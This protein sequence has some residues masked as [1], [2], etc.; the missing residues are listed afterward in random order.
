MKISDGDH[1]INAVVVD[2]RK[3][4]VDKSGLKQ[5]RQYDII[6]LS[7]FK[8]KQLQS[9]IS[10]KIHNF[11]SLREWPRC[12]SEQ[13]EIIGEPKEFTEFRDEKNF[14]DPQKP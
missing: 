2:P 5:I 1:F 6:E 8:L 3:G 4:N 14:T 12:L 13:T 9:K 7:R 11:I 10:Q